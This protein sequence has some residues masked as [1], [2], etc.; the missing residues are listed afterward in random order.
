MN[1]PV[2]SR[3]KNAFVWAKIAI[4]LKCVALKRK[5]RLYFIRKMLQKGGSL[6]AKAD[7]AGS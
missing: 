1:I 7:E 4:W 5:K 3:E 6:E 2:S